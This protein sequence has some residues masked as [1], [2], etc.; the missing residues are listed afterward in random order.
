MCKVRFE[1]LNSVHSN[2]PL[3]LSHLSLNFIVLIFFSSLR[4]VSVCVSWE[5]E[6]TWRG[7]IYIGMGYLPFLIIIFIFNRALQHSMEKFYREFPQLRCTE[8]QLKM[9]LA[10]LHLQQKR[11]AHEQN[12]RLAVS[13]QA[14]WGSVALWGCSRQANWVYNKLWQPQLGELPWEILQLSVVWDFT[15]YTH[16]RT[17]AH[18]HTNSF[19]SL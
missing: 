11:V 4:F 17:H 18:L 3:P 10:S 2:F 7:K 9:R 12:T 6:I 19:F 5:R 1:E 15:I 14:Q 13:S 8:L 16:A